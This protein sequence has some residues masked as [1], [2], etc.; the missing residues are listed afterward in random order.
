MVNLFYRKWLIQINFYEITKLFEMLSITTD[1]NSYSQKKKLIKIFSRN[2]YVWTDWTVKKTRHFVNE[3]VL[4][5]YWIELKI[6]QNKDYIFLCLRIF[7][8]RVLLLWKCFVAYFVVIVEGK[9]FFPGTCISYFVWIL[10]EVYG[11]WVTNE[12][13]SIYKW[14]LFVE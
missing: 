3:E 8:K 1:T 14:Y 13:T 11:C 2:E 12:F 9:K 10:K 6:V 7:I 5:F 4:F